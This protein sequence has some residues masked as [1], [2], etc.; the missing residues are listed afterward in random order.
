[1]ELF[2][3]NRIY[4]SLFSNSYKSVEPLCEACDD[5]KSDNLKKLILD[6][7]N[8]TDVGVS[9]GWKPPTAGIS[10][11]GKEEA[12]R[13]D[14]RKLLQ[15]H[16]D[17]EFSSRAIARL[18]QGISSPCFPAEDWCRNRSVWRR[19]LDVDFHFLCQVAAQEIC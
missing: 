13:Q 14:I 1:M 17:I 9:A 5:V 15:N 16:T 6:Y 10:D 2:Q 19:H 12:I 4:Q 11:S 18:F 8:S 7:F 3:L